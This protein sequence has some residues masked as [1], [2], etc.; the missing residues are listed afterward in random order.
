LLWETAC[1]LE[2]T[3]QQPVS[4]QPPAASQEFNRK[5]GEKYDALRTKPGSSDAGIQGE[6]V[7]SRSGSGHW[8]FV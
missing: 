7:D 2:R 5:E 6:I 1:L 8:E 3:G 4:I